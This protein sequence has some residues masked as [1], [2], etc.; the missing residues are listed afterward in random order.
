MTQVLGDIYDF[1]KAITEA[2]RVLKSGGHF[3]LSESL[4]NETHNEPYDYWRFTEFSL[5]KLLEDAGMEIVE[6]KYRGGF[7]S[8]STQNLIR[9]LINGF[10]LNKNKALGDLFKIPAYLFTRFAVFLD[11]LDRTKNN[12]KFTIGYT[13]ISKKK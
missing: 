1:E 10:E 3:L 12:S 8:S 13:V 7:W 6:I 9:Y 2:S 11:S 5:R 4:I